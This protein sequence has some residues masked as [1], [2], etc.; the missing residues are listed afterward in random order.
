MSEQIPIGITVNGEDLEFDRAVTVTELLA[1][2][3]LPS[4]GIAV[5]VDGA[6]FPRG[7]WDESVERG[8]EIEILTAVQ[9]G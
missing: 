4:K 2:R 3:G 5:A 6:L 7:R 9:G 8:W 1:H